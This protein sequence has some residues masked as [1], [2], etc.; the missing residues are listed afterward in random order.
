[1][2]VM[3]VA[4]SDIGRTEDRI[5]CLRSDD[6]R[7]LLDSVC[8]TKS[9]R[10]CMYTGQSGCV[11]VC[12]TKSLCICVYAA[13]SHVRHRGPQPLPALRRPPR[14]TRLGAVG[15]A[16]PLVLLMMMMMM[17][18]IMVITMM[19]MIHDHNGDDD[20]VVVVVVVVD[21]DDDDDD[22]MTPTTP[23]TV[24]VIFEPS[25]FL[26]KGVQQ[27]PAMVPAEDERLLGTPYGLL[28]NELA[29]SPTQVYCLHLVLLAQATIRDSGRADDY[30]PFPV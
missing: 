1:M 23:T 8:T 15:T 9:L 14:P 12:G 16:Q 21:D 17:M 28:L 30:G 4:P 3:N 26:A 24:Q 25:R 2:V 13:S 11:F 7:D 19:I 10:V 29:R 18:I 22:D 20:I 5:H 27:A 6:L